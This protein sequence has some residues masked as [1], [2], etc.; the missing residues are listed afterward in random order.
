MQAAVS[1]VAWVVLTLALLLGCSPSSIGPDDPDSPGSEPVASDT[2]SVPPPPRPPVGGCY[3][4]RRGD[5]VSPTSGR[6]PVRCR[7]R[8]TSATFH[9]GRLDPSI[10]GRRRAVDARVVRA[11]VA[12]EC[13]T[14]LPRHLGGGVRAL[15]LSM[16]TSVWFT[17]TVE[18]SEAGARWFRCDVIA[19]ASSGRLLDLPRATRGLLAT[20]AGRERFGMC[21]T[22][23]PGSR[24]F[25]RVACQSRHAWVAVAAVDLGGPGYPAP[26]RVAA[27]MEPACREA[28]RARSDD[29]LD[30]TWSEER[31]TRAQWRAG[32][33]YGLCWVP[34]SSRSTRAPS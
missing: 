15:R 18:E 8:H 11:R 33:R 23:A 26:S 6:R 17:P 20:R 10:G 34:R 3:R 27:R 19:L 25:E 14:R 32:R 22:A 12:R 31:P 29:P 21:G 1:P 7:T 4:L 2:A 5:A 13:A 9:V 28:A 24:A 30:L 16:L